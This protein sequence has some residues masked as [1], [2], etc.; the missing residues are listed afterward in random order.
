MEL[1]KGYYQDA[2]RATKGTKLFPEV[3]VTQLILESGYSPSKL[4]RDANNWFGIKAGS[5]W[6]GKV[7][8]APTLE[9]I[10][11]RTVKIPGNWKIYN[12]RTDAVRDGQLTSSLF[13]VYSDRVAGFAGWVKFLYDN[14]RYSRAGVFQ[15][16][17]VVDQFAALARAGY[18][19]DPQYVAKLSAIYSKIKGFFLQTPL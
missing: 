5:A 13:R 9:V 12:S 15:A 14:P 10:N 18:A 1:I 6:T 17:T 19:T 2:L 11:K 16:K 3:L 4:A 8:S 7:I